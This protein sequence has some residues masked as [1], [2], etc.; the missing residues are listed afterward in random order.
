MET[1]TMSLD[2][3]DPKSIFEKYLQAV[4]KG[5]FTQA[6]QIIRDALQIGMLPETIYEEVFTPTLRLMGHGWETGEITV[7]QEHLA[8]GITEYCRNLIYNSKPI[9]PSN[10]PPVGKVLLTS[11]NGNNHTLGLNLLSDVFQWHGWEVY[12]LFCSLPQEEIATA[13]LIYQVDLICLSVALPAQISIATSTVWF[14]RQSDWKG[15]IEVGGA[16]FI[17]YPEVALQTGADFYAKTA[18]DAVEKATQLLK[19]RV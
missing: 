14:L 6:S 2:S 7:A 18:V 11:V 16:A 3:G 1:P 13:A 8:T 4:Q 19:A 17:N 10:S 15:L 9:N 5:T 12:P